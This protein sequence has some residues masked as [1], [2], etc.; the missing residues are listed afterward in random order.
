VL[1]PLPEGTLSTRF[2]TPLMQQGIGIPAARRPAVRLRRSRN[3]PARRFFHA[4]SGAAD[5]GVLLYA[6]KSR[7]SERTA[8]INTQIRHLEQRRNRPVF[9]TARSPRLPPRATDRGNQAHEGVPGRRPF[10][11]TAYPTQIGYAILGDDII[12]AMNAKGTA[13]CGSMPKP[14]SRPTF[15]ISALRL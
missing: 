13:I 2:A 15:L 9:P 14:C 8:E 10:W 11:P 6:T 1:C 12:Q 7:S 5:S 4:A 3:G